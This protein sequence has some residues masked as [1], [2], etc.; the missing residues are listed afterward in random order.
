MRFD[1]V[2]PAQGPNYSAERATF[3]VFRDG[4]QIA[5]MQP[6]KRFYPV[7]ATQTTEAAIRTTLMADLYVVI[8]DQTVGQDI[9]AVRMYHNPLVPWIWFGSLMMFGAGLVSLSDRRHRVGA[10][11]RA[12]APAGT[13]PRPA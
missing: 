8:G 11:T 10:P 4:E 7:S 1:G 9:W 13:A 6:E 2:A 12:R 3:T 5:V